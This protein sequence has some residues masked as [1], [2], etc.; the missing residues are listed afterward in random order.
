MPW[1]VTVTDVAF[2]DV[3]DT[4]TLGTT[5]VAP[6]AGTVMATVGAAVF[7]VKVEVAVVL[8]LP[9]ASTATAVTV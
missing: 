9:A 8:V 6:L 5:T 7:T 3:P 1:N 4:V 2:A